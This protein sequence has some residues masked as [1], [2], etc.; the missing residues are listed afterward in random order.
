M[1]KTAIVSALAFSAYAVY[2]NNSFRIRREKIGGGIK[3]MHISDIHK[4]RFG[5]NHCKISRIA[6]R[7]RPDLIFL[8]GDTVSR[9]QKD[10]TPE[11]IL[12]E[13]LCKTAP[14]Y[15]VLGNHEGDLSEYSLGRFTDILENS[16]AVLLRNET[17]SININSRIINICGLEL[18]QTV[19]KKNGSYKNLD[20]PGIEDIYSLL[21]RC[22]QGE[23]LLLAHNPLFGELYSVWGADYTFCGHVHGGIIN[24]LG[25]GVLSP[26]RKLFPKY[27]KGIYEI[28]GRKLLVSAGMGKFRL[29]NP[30]EIVIYEI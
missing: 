5:K 14:V 29:F 22:P 16:G 1:K 20:I 23:T 27:S 28:N 30:S 21:G 18:P 13:N 4:R 8:T 26:E 9:T 6:E 11:K 7:E 25:R 15:A 17:R 3:I 19:Y 2:E 10:F 12:I 24:I